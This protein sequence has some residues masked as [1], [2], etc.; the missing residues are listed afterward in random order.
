MDSGSEITK[1]FDQL[2][3]K[4]G[5]WPAE[6]LRIT[7]AALDDML[8]WA[9]NQGAS[10]VTIQTDRP[11]YIE[12]DGILFP[13]TRRNLDPADLTII[14]NRIYGT[15][16]LAK[17]ASGTDLDLSYEVRLDRYTRYRFRVNITAM[18][19]RGRDSVQITLRSLPSL[20]PTMKE[21]GVEQKIIENWSPRQGLILVTGPTGSGKTTLLASGCRML[22][23]RSEG[24]GKLLTYEAPIEFVYDAIT[25]PRSLVAQSEI[26]RHLP[27]FAAGV[28]NALRRKPNIILVGESRDRETVTAA[29]EAG[30]TGHLVFST[31]HTIGVAATVR[32]IVSVFDPAERTER[33]FA[34]IETLRMVVT[35]ALVPKVGG[36]RIG[37]REY[38][39]F[40]EVV[41][42]TLLDL[43]I[44]R[45]TNE[46]QRLLLRHGQSMEQTATRAFKSGVIDRRTYL[47]LVKGYSGSDSEKD[48]AETQSEEV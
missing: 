23:E 31:V 12:V 45:W 8:V 5:T 17:L 4:L 9:V 15:D 1:N 46:T 11:V 32:R 35:Q 6:P 19:S 34:M 21:L 30:Q 27:S 13:V 2:T 14:L 22:I 33:A 41:R 3:A 36:G 18:M 39:V 24:C 20:P 43:P 37:L 38:M 42:E 29:V 26:P 48:E 10:D 25:G 44:E 47:H 7:D 28:R 16:A 40:D